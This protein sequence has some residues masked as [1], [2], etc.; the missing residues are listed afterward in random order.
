MANVRNTYE[1][2]W[3][4]G[5]IDNVKRLLEIQA[6]RR[7]AAD[8]YAASLATEEASSSSFTS[9]S[10][11][12][13]VTNGSTFELTKMIISANEGSYTTV[14]GSDN[15]HGV[16]IGKFQWHEGRALALLQAMR[17]AD[18]SLFDSTLISNGGQ[19]I[20]TKMNIK[21]WDELTFNSA[22][23]AATKKLLAIEKFQAVQDVTADRDLQGYI[24]KGTSLGLSDPKAIAYFADL[25]NQRPASAV[26]IAKS[27]LNN[28]GSLEAI[29]SA[30]MSDSIMSA[31]KTRRNN[32]YKKL[33]EAVINTPSGGS[34]AAIGKIA[35][36]SIAGGQVVLP[37]VDRKKNQAELY[38]V[39]RNMKSTDFANL[40]SKLYSFPNGQHS[41]M[42]LPHF[43]QILYLLHGVVAPLLGVDKLVASSGL[44]TK[45]VDEAKAMGV[46][47]VDP[48]M[49]AIAIDIFVKG[50]GKNRFIVA[51]AAWSIGLRAIG[52]GADHVHIDAGP[53]AFWREH[54]V[55]KIYKGPGRWE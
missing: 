50:G 55:S 29:H 51:D 35:I 12:T 4:Q 26:T 16:S 14:A 1:I 6:I 52:V 33:A 17:A 41:N 18:S 30:A 38:A 7:D 44:R 9:S 48:H 40:D 2:N 37:N 53:G 15:S 23:V 46:T 47:T 10:G 11:S 42:F 36:A 3:E 8:A 13:V 45:V 31:Y 25:Y 34:S 32:T 21:S 22:E 19:S 39:V 49:A 24:D 20:L 43:A 28:G 5:Y 54:D 27:A